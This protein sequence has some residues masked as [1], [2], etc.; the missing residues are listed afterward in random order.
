MKERINMEQIRFLL[1]SKIEDYNEKAI[2]NKY[3]RSIDKSY[4]KSLPRR[5]NDKNLTRF[6]IIYSMLQDNDIM[7]CLICTNRKPTVNTHKGQNHI[8]LDMSLKD[9]KLLPI[10]IVNE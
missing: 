1:K 8:V 9:Y 7:R 5:N 6:P 2:K 10:V 4:L 3:N